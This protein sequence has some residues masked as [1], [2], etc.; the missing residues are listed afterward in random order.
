MFILF[1]I[2]KVNMLKRMILIIVLMVC[3]TQESYGQPAIELLTDQAQVHGLY[4]N[5]ASALLICEITPYGKCVFDR[6]KDRPF[7][8]GA[9]QDV[10]LE[11]ISDC[12]FI[13][14]SNADELT[15]G[16]GVTLKLS[17]KTLEE[18]RSVAENC[19]VRLQKRISASDALLLW[20]AQKVEKNKADSPSRLYSSLERLSDSFEG[21]QKMFF[22]LIR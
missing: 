15:V 18:I 21:A 1:N 20:Q 2:K 13:E 10:L 11:L 17:C 6:C 5:V 19:H 4:S 16:E 14:L 9:K 22:D 8:V 3:Y 12:E 7:Q